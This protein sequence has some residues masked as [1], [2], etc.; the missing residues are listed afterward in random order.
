VLGLCDRFRCLPERGSLLEQDAS[1]LR[2][3]K[4]A[5]MGAPARTEPDPMAVFGG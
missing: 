5:A 1:I 2:L 4:I 3:V